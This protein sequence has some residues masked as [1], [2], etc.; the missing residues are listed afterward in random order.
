MISRLAG[1]AWAF[2]ARVEREAAARF[3]RLADEIEAFDL[4]SPVPAMMRR[5]ADDERRHLALCE[6]L[7]GGPVSGVALT[8]KRG[9][10]VVVGHAIETTTG[11][12]RMLE[13]NWVQDE[14]ENVV[15]VQIRRVDWSKATDSA[16][17]ENR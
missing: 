14:R 3:G 15:D 10:G 8:G 5:A 17:G 4:Q 12:D 6:E 16:S 11:R 1:Q 2:R 9:I 7:A 13:V